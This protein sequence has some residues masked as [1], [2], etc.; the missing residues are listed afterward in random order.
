MSDVNEIIYDF[1]GQLLKSIRKEK[2]LTQKQLEELCGINEV[3]IRRY[4][5]NRV[6]PK[7]DNLEKLALALN[8]SEYELMKVSDDCLN[9]QIDTDDISIIS[10]GEKIRYYRKQKGL[11]QKQLGKKCDIVYQQIGHYEQGRYKPSKD[12]LK[13]MQMH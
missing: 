7:M 3:Q 10:I 13:K 8:V 11:T 1:N 2:G 12:T 4:E 5:S 9:N 6:K